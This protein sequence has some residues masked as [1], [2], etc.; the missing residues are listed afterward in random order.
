MT[1]LRNIRSFNQLKKEV[2]KGSKRSA[3]GQAYTEWKR[4]GYRNTEKLVRA[5]V[6]PTYRDPRGDNSAS[7]DPVGFASQD[8]KKRR[9]EL[10]EEL[11]LSMV[12][13]GIT[14]GTKNQRLGKTAGT[15]IGAYRRVRSTEFR[16]RSRNATPY[17]QYANGRRSTSKPY[18]TST[19]DKRRGKK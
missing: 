19:L 7:Y 16:G 12:Q 14:A 1:R 3:A 13:I 9:Q 4:T 15:T 5:T 10:I 8:E 6:D 18:R 2:T 17:K 11:A